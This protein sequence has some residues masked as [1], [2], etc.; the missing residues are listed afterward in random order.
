MFSIRIQEQYFY[1]REKIDDYDR[2]A[3][4]KYGTPRGWLM[5]PTDA[6]DL[7]EAP[8]NEERSAVEE[9]EWRTK[10][11]EKYF[12][13]IKE[14]TREMTTWTGQHLG[15]V[16]MGQPYRAGGG[17]LRVTIRV[18]GTNGVT[19]FGTYFKG[20]GSYCRIRLAK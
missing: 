18:H 11:P 10:P 7:P 12:A 17:D 1:L 8:T 2:A 19:Y 3:G 20:A 6:E 16:I 9:Y 13:Y 14:E 5:V 15:D 4:A